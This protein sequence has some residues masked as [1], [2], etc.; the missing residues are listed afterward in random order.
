[1]RRSSLVGIVPLLSG[2]VSLAHAQPT[3][4]GVRLGG[5][6]VMNTT[7]LPVLAGSTDCGT[8]GDG[9]A[10]GFYGGLTIDHAVVD[11]LVEL[12]GAL[13]YSVRPATLTTMSADALEVLDPVT[14]QHV[15]FRR[16]HRFEAPLGYVVADIGIRLRPLTS[17]PAWIRLSVDAGNPIVSASYEQTETIVQPSSVLFPG[18]LKRRITGSGTLV[19][20]GTVY[21]GNLSVGAVIPWLEN[22]ELLPEL[23]YRFGINDVVHSAPWGQSMVTA[24]I[25]I[26]Y[27][28]HDERPLPL[29]RES[30]PAPVAERQ[31]E[32]AVPV[33]VTITSLTTTPL[34]IQETLVTQT[35][36]LLPYI[37]FDSTLATIRERYTAT[38]AVSSFREHDLP[39]QTLAIYYR[40][41]DV[42]G[43][44]MLAT[45]AAVLTVTGT[46]DGI[47]VPTEAARRNLAETRARAVIDYLRGRW[48]IAASRFQ[49]RTQ[50]RPTLPSSERYREGLEE[51]RRVE[52]ASSV[53]SILAPVVHTRFNEY[54]PVVPRHDFGV[55]LRNPE[56]ARSWSLDI[57]RQ[58][59]PID[60]RTGN[61][62]PPSTVAFD[63]TQGTT[64]RLGPLLD[65]SDMLEATMQVT[66]GDGI[67]PVEA[68]TTFPIRKTTNAVEV[69]RL[70]LIVFDFDQSVIAQHNKDMMRQVIAASTGP[71]SRAVIK[72]STDRLGEQ[73]HN[74]ELSAARARAVEQYLRSIA[75]HVTTDEV[76]GVG[77]SELP[78]DNTLPE[79][80]FYCRTVSLTIT[81]PLR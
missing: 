53:P 1:M 18:G 19:D 59:A 63:L 71:G 77:A 38:D 44:R 10:M 22:V 69:S 7:T 11:G 62:V 78:Y 28:M 66:Q 25:Q 31:P 58:G 81:T 51:N 4:L 12:S 57:H 13:L 27:V 30:A 14:N 9:A 15:P 67:E 47:E 29:L 54:L 37:F 45:P 35:F 68:T 52:L 80:R 34:E 72:G 73:A 20:A 24:G 17:V 16:E 76:R 49:V 40:S 8:F 74:M 39:R 26:R 23:G 61:G 60:R 65:A 46:T 3:A 55:V 41:L 70:S 6:Y 32:V 64:D 21:G 79:G 36:P 48:G 42:I 43:S 5:Q 2:L 56:Q 75:P 50:D 33:P